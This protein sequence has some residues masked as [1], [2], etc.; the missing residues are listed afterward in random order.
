M[1]YPTTTISTL[2]TTM[3]STLFIPENEV[4]VGD[5]DHSECIIGEY[6]P[7]ND[8]NKVNIMRILKINNFYFK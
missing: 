8:C 7:H 4:P 6:I 1:K 3:F 5:T 2:S